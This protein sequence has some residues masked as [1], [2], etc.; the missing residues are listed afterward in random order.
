[1][2]YKSSSEKNH[3][4][5]ERRMFL[6]EREAKFIVGVFK[7]EK[8]RNFEKFL[9]YA[10]AT[11]NTSF[12]CKHSSKLCAYKNSQ[13]KMFFTADIVGSFHSLSHVFVSICLFRIS[14]G[15]R[16]H[17]YFSC[18]SLSSYLLKYQQ[19]RLKI[20]FPTKSKKVI[21][22]IDSFGSV[23][24]HRIPVKTL[25]NSS[26]HLVLISLKYVVSIVHF[27]ISASSKVAMK[28]R[29]VT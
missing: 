11:L 6:K 3:K 23:K 16:F 21:W 10:N 27:N 8:W 7:R 9:Y 12:L 4:T 24:N 13:M 2:Y 20:W 17:F 25:N 19:N 29:S 15:N 14:F 26:K 22:P 5:S 1:M 18:D 28:F